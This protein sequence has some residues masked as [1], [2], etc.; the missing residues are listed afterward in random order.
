MQE[1]DLWVNHFY[2]DI[3]SKIGNLSKL[4][5]LDLS[6]NNLQGT[7]HLLLFESQFYFSI[8]DCEFQNGPNKTTN[9]LRLKI[10]PNRAKEVN[11]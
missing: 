7:F 6:D 1:L 2:G 8:P 4:V 5:H 3:H 11:C 9:L 10:F